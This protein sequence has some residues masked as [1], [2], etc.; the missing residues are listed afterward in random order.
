MKTWQI[1]V[2]IIVFVFLGTGAYAY[3]TYRQANQLKARVTG[4]SL[5]NPNFLQDFKAIDTATFLDKRRLDIYLDMMVSNYGNRDFEITQAFMS[6]IN[7][8]SG[9]KIGETTYPLTEP[10]KIKSGDYLKLKIPISIDISEAL[11][12][13]FEGNIVENIF[14]FSTG[15]G[16]QGKELKVEGFMRERNN[17]L[18]IPIPIRTTFKL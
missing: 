9:K 11:N 2:L 16:K 15:L 13:L 8:E 4:V 12:F 7:P 5:Q 1:I 18:N 17:L 3:S 10:I 6:V 14:K